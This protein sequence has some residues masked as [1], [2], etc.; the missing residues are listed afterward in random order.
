MSYCLFEHLL[1]FYFVI[2]PSPVSIS[3][4]VL[5]PSSE[6]YT[7]FT[8]VPTV[9]APIQRTY[10]SGRGVANVNSSHLGFA[11][12][13]VSAQTNDGQHDK[14][15]P[16]SHTPTATPRNKEDAAV[17]EEWPTQSWAEEEELADGENSVEVND[18]SKQTPSTSEESEPQPTEQ[19]HPY[20]NVVEQ[21]SDNRGNRTYSTSVTRR[22]GHTHISTQEV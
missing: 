12:L 4:Q 7:Q 19:G 16:S 11:V 20:P 6:N 2:P 13:S 17:E 15:K 8:A 5:H 1:S 14:V 18:I 3:S 21:L 10:R 22:T 9:P